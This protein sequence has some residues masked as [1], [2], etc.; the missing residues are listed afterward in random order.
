MWFVPAGN[1]KPNG[2]A[3]PIALMLIGSFLSI[4]IYLKS[5]ALRKISSHLIHKA[6]MLMASLFLGAHIFICTSVFVKLAIN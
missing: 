6:N 4:Y 1:I 5:N 3:F 2:F